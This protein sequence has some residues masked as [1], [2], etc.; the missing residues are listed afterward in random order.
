MGEYAKAEPLYLQ[1]LEIRKGPWAKSIP[2]RQTSLNNLAGLHDSMG[3]YA[4][5]EPLYLQALEIRQRSWAK[6][7]PTTHKPEQPGRLYKAMGDYAKAE[8]LYRQAMEIR[9]KVLRVKSIPTMGKA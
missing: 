5:A 7:I 4:K 1:A 8:P 3:E 9:K 2:I 6:S